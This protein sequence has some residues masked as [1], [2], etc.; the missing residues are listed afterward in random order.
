[1]ASITI[2]EGL[3]Y[4]AVLGTI[5]I[6]VLAIYRLFF[7][8]LAQYPGPKLAA[9]SQL[10]FIRAWTSGRYPFVMRHQVHDRYGDVV[11][12]APNELSFRSPVAYKDI[13]AR[14][15]KEGQFLKSEILY[16]TGSAAMRPNI[17][18]SRDPQDHRQ[19]RNGLSHAFS[20]HSLNEAQAVIEDYTELFINQI[21]EKGGPETNGVD[22]SIVYNWLTFDIIGQL[23]FGESFDCIKQWK[24]SEWVTLILDFATQLSLGTVLNR[25]SVPTFCVSLFLPTTLKNNLISHDRITDG[26][27]LRLIRD[28]KGQDDEHKQSLEKSYFFDRTIRESEFDPVHLREQAK[29][30]MLAGS[31]TTATFLAGITYLLLNTPETL[32]KLQKE[33]RSAFSSKKE[34][35]KDSTLK[36]QYLSGVIEEGLRLFPPAPFGLPRVCPPGAM[37]DGRAVPEG[38]VVSV[39]SFA[40]SHDARNFSDP[41][42]FRPERWVGVGTEDNLSASRPFS[43]GRRACLGFKIAYMEARTIL[44]MMV[45]T[46]NWELVNADLQWFEEVRF[47]MTWKKPQLLVRFHPRQQKPEHCVA[48][49]QLQP[50][51]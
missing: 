26:K 6:S 43:I 9:C 31:E 39:D 18:F 14:V 16:S 36:L 27:I 49:E 13:Y 1:M 28:S 19:Q 45:Y 5:W 25:L 46:Y 48:P 40:M 3:L 34:I 8:P 21:G 47:H 35:T 41:D 20:G 50:H 24:H 23:T 38:T 51:S 32:V 33:V 12:I 29:V 11:R 44:A 7:H 4:A 2:F 10:W 30:M 37:I 17:V 42:V 22:V 15:S